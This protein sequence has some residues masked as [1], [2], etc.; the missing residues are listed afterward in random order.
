MTFDP[1]LNMVNLPDS[2]F[3]SL[4]IDAIKNVVNLPESPFIPLI[5]AIYRSRAP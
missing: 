3:I 5:D 2:P 4:I 1:N